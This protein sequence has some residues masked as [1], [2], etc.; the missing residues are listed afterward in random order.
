MNRN[1]NS[2][3]DPFHNSDTSKFVVA[4]RRGYSNNDPFFYDNDTHE[5]SFNG[6]IKLKICSRQSNAVN[7]FETRD[8]PPFYKGEQ[9]NYCA[10]KGL[11]NNDKQSNIANSSERAQP[12]I[13]KPNFNIYISDKDF[14]GNNPFKNENSTPLAN[15]S[16]GKKMDSFNMLNNTTSEEEREVNEMNLNESLCA[17]DPAPVNDLRNRIEQLKIDDGKTKEQRRN[18][19]RKVRKV[20]DCEKIYTNEGNTLGEDYFD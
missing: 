20:D 9:A 2:P 7:S 14:L 16:R 12:L 17:P 19:Y 11:N 3:F 15:N 6:T 5:I 8:K 10:F 4:K 13:I 1:A 18:E